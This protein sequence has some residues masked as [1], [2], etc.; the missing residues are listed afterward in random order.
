MFYIKNSFNKRHKIIEIFGLKIKIKRRNINNNLD[1]KV[2]GKSH[3]ENTLIGK[4]TY[5][6]DN[7]CIS[8]TQIG[9]YCSIGPNLMCGYG[10][11]PTNGLS[12]SPCFYSTYK[13]NGFSYSQTNKIDERLPIVIGNDVWI[14]MNVCILDGVKIGDG[15]II[16]AGAV[17]TKDVPPYAIVGGVPAKIIRYRF[18]DEIIEALLKIKWWDWEDEKIKEVEKYFFDID[19]FIKK[20]GKM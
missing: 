11:H 9:K 2:C 16:G 6:S 18:S 10:I 4:G 17:V 3:I 1:Y 5:I 13:Q 14:G 8:L 20:Y 19:S 15:A 7:S 12:T